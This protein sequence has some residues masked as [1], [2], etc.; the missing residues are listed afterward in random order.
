M[1][2]LLCAEPISR[3]NEAVV[4]LVEERAPV[5]AKRQSGRSH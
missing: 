2:L 4:G 3:G 5:P 1:L